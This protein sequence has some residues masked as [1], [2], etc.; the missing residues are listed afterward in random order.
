MDILDNELVRKYFENEYPEDRTPATTALRILRA[1]EEPI[2]KGERLLDLK[3]DGY[4]VES[5]WKIHIACTEFHPGFLR[6]PDRFQK[7][8]C[9]HD[10]YLRCVNCGNNFTT[11]WKLT[12]PTPEPAL[13][14]CKDFAGQCQHPGCKPKYEVEEKIN[15][16]SAGDYKG[17]RDILRELV[18]MARK[19][20]IDK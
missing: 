1:M 3:P 6:L 20:I 18:D 11:G 9:D 14:K 13:F 7:Q 10:G 17:L 16:W 12:K 19:N 4:A 5:Q 2:K 8:G 15:G